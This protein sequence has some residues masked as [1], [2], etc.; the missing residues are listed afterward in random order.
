MV[1]SRMAPPRMIACNRGVRGNR[2][3]IGRS[4]SATIRLISGGT[5][6]V[7]TA[8]ASLLLLWATLSG[9]AA[10][11]CGRAPE[12]RDPALKIELEEGAWRIAWNKPGAPRRSVLIS[13]LLAK[14]PEAAKKED[15]EAFLKVEFCL[16]A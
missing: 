16:L 13:E 5:E 12:I 10:D 6:T 15:L 3:W 11:S 14:Y 2:S 1:H 8:T 7:R 4:E 9:A